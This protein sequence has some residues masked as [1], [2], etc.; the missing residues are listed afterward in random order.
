[1]TNSYVLISKRDCPWC[2]KAKD[3]MTRQGFQ[4]VEVDITDDDLA[5]TALKR[6][7]WRTVPIIVPMGKARTY[8]GFEHEVL[9]GH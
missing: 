2:D 1:M 8:Q 9:S 5:K 7:G 3:F 4:F 6:V